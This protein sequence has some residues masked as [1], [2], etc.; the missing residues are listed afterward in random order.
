ML[1][2]PPLAPTV[3]TQL[4]PTLAHQHAAFRAASLDALCVQNELCQVPVLHSLW[5]A[6]PLMAD[7]DDEVRH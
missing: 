1:A 7:A 6:L 3:I 2:S 4:L 5:A